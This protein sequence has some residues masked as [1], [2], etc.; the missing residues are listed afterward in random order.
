MS[1]PPGAGALKPLRRAWLWA[2]LW[3]LAVAVVVVLS[4]VPP[5]PME[6]PRHGDKAEHLLAYALLAAAAEEV[7]LLVSGIPVRIR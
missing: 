4:L 2:G 3:W 5:P 6:L 7:V 1:A